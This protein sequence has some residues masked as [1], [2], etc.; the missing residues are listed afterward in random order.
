[1]KNDNQNLKSIIQCK[2]VGLKWEAEVSI[3]SLDIKIKQTKI[4]KDEAIKTA[5][6]KALE[7]AHDVLS[8]TDLEEKLNMNEEELKSKTFDSNHKLLKTVSTLIEKAIDE[9]IEQ[10]DSFSNCL[11]KIVDEKSI[12]GYEINDFEANKIGYHHLY[13]GAAIIVEV[14]V[15][16]KESYFSKRNELLRDCFDIRKELISLSD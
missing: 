1:M 5:C 12:N 10:K 4:N 2:K 14:P 13:K 16:N 6:L 3:P 8:K 7:Y 9:I 11:I 15:K